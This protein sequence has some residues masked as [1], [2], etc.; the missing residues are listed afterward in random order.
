MALILRNQKWGSGYRNVPYR[1]IDGGTYTALITSSQALT[2]PTGVAVGNQGTAGTTTYGYRVSAVG[3]N[4]ETLAAAEATTTTGNATLT[5]VN[6]N[7][8]TWSA[9]T[10]AGGYNIYRST[11]GATQGKIGF[12]PAGVLTFDDIGLAAAGVVPT[13]NT[14]RSY[15]IFIPSLK[16]AG[17]SVANK[18]NVPTLMT[19]NGTGGL[20]VGR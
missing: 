6:F 5:G 18:T 16:P 20:V 15:N 17:A 13:G 14:A 11:G 12:S 10:G 19:R 2:T 7:R 3:G 4:G 1:H 9:V 8:I